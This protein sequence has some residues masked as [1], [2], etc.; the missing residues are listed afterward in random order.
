MKNITIPIF[1]LIS[2]LFNGCSTNSKIA[3]NNKII[4]GFS[5]IEGKVL[6]IFGDKVIVQVV[7]KD[8]II[9]DK[10]EDTL[11]NKVI[12]ASI[13]INGMK[14]YIGKESAY[15]EDI[16]DTQVTFNIKDTKLIT[17]QK[18]KI[19]I[20]KKTI[21]VMDFSIIGMKNKEF[22]KIAMEDI[23]TSLVQSGQYTVVERTKLD[24]ILKEHKLAD[25]G[26]IDKNSASKIGKFISA[27]LILT[28]S[29][30]KKTNH[31]N[32]NLRIID[33]S[34]GIIISAINEKIALSKFRPKQLLDSTN[35]NT[36]FEKNKIDQHWAQNIVNKFGSR[37]NA[38]I[39][40][41][42]GANGTTKSLKINYFLPKGKSKSIFYN[43]RLRDLSNY[44]GI[45]FFA[46]ASKFTTLSVAFHDQNYNNAFINRW[47]TL[48]N[49]NE[50]WKEYKIPFNELIL[51][52]RYANKFPKGDGVFDLDNIES[53]GFALGGRINTKKE[54]INIWLDEITFY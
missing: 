6:E 25:S 4:Y 16:R 3:Q 9:S 7:N 51:N 53:F 38:S 48:I 5:F 33:V 22:N 31:W 29:F 46:K 28:G 14:T 30:T 40:T 54:Y 12:K 47:N 11:T 37:S 36:S 15:I 39:D 41:A 27:N 34:S 43:K 44:Q 13:F 17:D 19:Y 2:I 24:T 49:V 8:V 21:A 52:K 10:Y 35:L 23:T 20:P 45:R 26:L 32:V 42:N 18:V 50:Q 1:I